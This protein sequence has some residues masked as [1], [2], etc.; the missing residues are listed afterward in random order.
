[1]VNLSAHTK[2]R[3]LTQYNNTIQN[4]KKTRK[5]LIDEGKGA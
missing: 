5:V 4:K 2:H 3:H 1:M